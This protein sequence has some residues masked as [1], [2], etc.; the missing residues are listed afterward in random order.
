MSS[1]LAV[2][3]LR[4]P[5]SLYVFA[6]DR[7]EIDFYIANTTSGNTVINHNVVQSGTNPLLPF[8]GVNASGI[9]RM[10]GFATF[11]ECSNARSI[12]EEGPPVINPRDT[13]PPVTD[14]FKKQMGQLIDG[15]PV[16]G[17]LVKTI[18][19]VVKFVGKFK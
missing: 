12:I 8:G 5:L 11:N 7:A 16:P 1:D 14:K 13:L 10:L 19:A 15:K 17:A 2:S 9:G 18:D 4:K 6:K 3:A